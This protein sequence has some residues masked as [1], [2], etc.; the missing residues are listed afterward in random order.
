MDWQNLLREC[1]YA[2][3]RPG[4]KETLDQLL[5]GKDVLTL[6]PTGSGKS[7]CYLAVAKLQQ[8]RE[9][10]LRLAGEVDLPLTDEDA[11]QAAGG[12]VLK[13]KLSPKAPLV[14]VISPLIA[15]M[16][17]QELKAKQ[18]GLE[19]SHLSS[20]LD[21]DE[22]EK[23]LR[24]IRSG[25][26]HVV[27][28]TPERL[29]KENFAQAVSDRALVL[30]AV[31]EAHCV[32]QWGHDFRPDYAKIKEFKALAKPRHYLALTATATP[33]MQ[34]D[35][36]K[37]LA[38]KDA[39]ILKLGLNRPNISLNVHEAYETADKITKLQELLVE[40]VPTI[41]YF[42]LIK[43]IYEVVSPLRAKQ[44][45]RLLLYHG[46]LNP[47][48]RRQNLKQFLQAKSP[49]M[50]A[51]P[52]FGLG[53]DRP[54][55]RRVIHFELPGSLE[56]YFQEVGRAGRDDLPAEGH[57]LYSEQDILIQME[58]LKWAYPDR[59]FMKTLYAKVRDQH[60]RLMTAEDPLALL[61]EEMSFKNRKDFRIDSGLNILERWGALEKTEDPFP[62]KPVQEPDDLQFE[63]EKP[64]ELL[65]VQHQRL[66]GLV[67]WAQNQ[68][69]CRMVEILNYFG[70]SNE[71]CGICDVC[72]G[73]TA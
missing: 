26:F 25:R 3:F 53:I 6:M 63:R 49:L 14:L 8:M 19:A 70:S 41:V 31:D 10:A 68:E 51:T 35:I 33:Q 16:Q 11:H 38:M 22:R 40:E 1:G 18:L 71:D 55:I 30:L 67:K 44:S 27:F 17:D 59:E 42:S 39:K 57:L 24:Q 65:R 20:N 58:F 60:S 48:Q 72:R 62:F 9:A 15:L 56:S 7:F 54:D 52:A 47:S 69:S 64:E 34:L 36:V 29:Q 50:L 13:P 21:F 23:R 45:S 73:A 37:D 12:A 28:V 5:A 2:H 4:Q 43:T 46:D 32:V 61:R 66:H